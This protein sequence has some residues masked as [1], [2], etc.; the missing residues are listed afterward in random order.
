MKLKTKS[1]NHV[2]RRIGSIGVC[3]QRVLNRTVQLLP[4]ASSE[5][6]VSTIEAALFCGAAGKVNELPQLIVTAFA[7]TLTFSLK[8]IVIVAFCGTSTA[9]FAGIVVVTDGAASDVKLNTKFASI[10]SGGSPAST[11]VTFAATTVTVQIVP[12]GKSDVGSSVK[13]LTPPGASGMTVKVTG[14]PL[15]IRL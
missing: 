7:D 5:G 14:V 2:V 13:L 6:G 15:D 12:N 11:S 8:L 9:L 3:N 10:L 4:A 1:V